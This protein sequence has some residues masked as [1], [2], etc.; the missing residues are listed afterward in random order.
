MRLIKDFE[1]YLKCENFSDNTKQSYIADI[2]AFCNDCQILS[3]G[4]ISDKLTADYIRKLSN[5]GASF[6]KISRTVSSIRAFH[7]FLNINI[8]VTNPLL[9]RKIKKKMPVI[10]D[11]NEIVNFLSIPKGDSYKSVRDKL[12]LKI[13]YYTGI[14]VS[15]LI[16]LT[17]KDINFE[18]GTVII[19]GN[20]ARVIPINADLISELDY[21]ITSF[22]NTL[23]ADTE[24]LFLNIKGEKLSRQGVWKIISYY[25]DKSE[26]KKEITPNTLRHSFATHLIDNGADIKYVK[27]LLGL[28]DTSSTS[29]YIEY[30]KGQYANRYLK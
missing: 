2:T 23:S 28:N 3:A 11:K 22:R 17:V 20:S 9:N 1:D 16:E 25:S 14:K 26:I 18:I 8:K 19:R 30:L 10:L 29:I 5:S 21:Y 7:K 4:E 6:S 27:S 24:F 12:I 13:M 15:E